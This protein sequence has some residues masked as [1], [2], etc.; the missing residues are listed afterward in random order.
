MRQIA[1]SDRREIAP[2]RL[3][4][5][6]KIPAASFVAVRLIERPRPEFSR[7]RRR[8]SAAEVARALGLLAASGLLGYI[9]LVPPS[10]GQTPKDYLTDLCIWSAW[11]L[12]CGV[13]GAMGLRRPGL[14]FAVRLLLMLSLAGLG[15]LMTLSAL[16]E[17]NERAQIVWVGLALICG[18]LGGLRD[19]V[20]DIVKDKAA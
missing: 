17:S 7:Y 8:V 3:P 9:A 10:K 5:S 4:S 18:G 1:R 6:L 12:L 13:V 16:G 11:P 15:V 2:V 20:R 19:I 14:A